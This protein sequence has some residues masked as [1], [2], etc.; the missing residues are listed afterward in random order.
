VRGLSSIQIGQAAEW[1]F[2]KLLILGSRG[3]LEATPALADEEGWDLSVHLK[4]RPETGML[5]QV[6][7]VTN[8]VRLATYSRLVVSIRWREHRFLPRR[9]LGA[10]AQRLA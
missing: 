6:K 8:L 2:Y 9:Q 1:E 5:F 4:G 3:R 7:C 10:L